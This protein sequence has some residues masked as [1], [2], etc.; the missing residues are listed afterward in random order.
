MEG[1]KPEYPEKTAGDEFQKRVDS[2]RGHVT[3]SRTLCVCGGGGGGGG[4]GGEAGIEQNTVPFGLSCAQK[5]AEPQ[6]AEEGNRTH[7]YHPVKTSR[8]RW[9]NLPLL[10]R[11]P[12]RWPSG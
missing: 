10:N 12:P 1:R 4:E 8:T 9:P 3:L 6:K 11:T 5:K 2:H 7:V